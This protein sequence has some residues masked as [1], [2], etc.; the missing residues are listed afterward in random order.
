MWWQQ[1]CQNPFLCGAAW[2]WAELCSRLLSDSSSGCCEQSLNP[3]LISVLGTFP[4]LGELFQERFDLRDGFIAAICSRWELETLGVLEGKRARRNCNHFKYS[5][6][7][8]VCMHFPS[9]AASQFG[10][11]FFFFWL[12]FL[13]FSSPLN[14]SIGM[15]CDLGKGTAASCWSRTLLGKRVR[16]FQWCVCFLESYIEGAKR[17]VSYRLKGLQPG[18]LNQGVL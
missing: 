18:P 7:I 9:L 14:H 2:L 13:D 8:A 16:T 6:V 4:V 3:F 10:R 5:L 15:G 12:D 1:K 17:C 11:G